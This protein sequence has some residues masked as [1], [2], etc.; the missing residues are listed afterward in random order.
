M[1]EI[2]DPNN[3]TLIYGTAWKTEATAEL[4]YKAVRAGFT[5][6]DTA[7]QKKHYQEDLVGEALQ[8]LAA[9][10]VSRRSLFLQSKFTFA[11]GHDHRIPYDPAAS[12]AAQVQSSFASTLENLRTDH[13]D[14]YLLHGPLSRDGLLEGDWQAWRAIEELQRAGK[15][16]RIGVCNVTVEQL[17]SLVAGADIRPAF[18]QNRCYAMYGWDQEVREYCQGNGIVYQGFSLITANGYVC[19]APEVRQIAERFAVTPAQVVLRFAQQ[20]SI[21]PLTGTKSDVHM[22]DDLSIGK[23]ELTWDDLSTIA[24]LPQ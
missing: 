20:I 13:L 16:R 23:F 4:V 1:Q 6:I 2:A 17:S 15:A 10:G 3:P 11:G 22:Q 14:S 5:A 9:E 8:R 7:N 19:R 18:V 21:L 12:Y 24:G